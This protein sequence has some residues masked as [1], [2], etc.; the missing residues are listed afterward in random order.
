MANPNPQYEAWKDNG[1]NIGIK[2]HACGRTRWSENDPTTKA[3]A[4]TESCSNCED[5]KSSKKI[6][7]EQQIHQNEIEAYEAELAQ[8]E[9]DEARAAVVFNCIHKSTQPNQ[10]LPRFSA[11]PAN[12]EQ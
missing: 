5:L 11:A 8:C 9:N 12:S 7:H 3:T 6:A 10:P 2:C 1:G 4:P